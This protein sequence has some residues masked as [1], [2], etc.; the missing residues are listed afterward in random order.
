[1][2]FSPSATPTF[3]R[4][5]IKPTAIPTVVLPGV[6]WSYYAYNGKYYSTIAASNGFDTCLN[7]FYYLPTDWILAPDDS[8]S[9]N[10]I[11]L[12]AWNTVTVVVASGRGYYSNSTY[13]LLNNE[14]S[15]WLSTYEDSHYKCAKCPCQVLIMY[16]PN[17]RKPSYSPVTYFPVASPSYFPIRYPSGTPSIKVDTT[18]LLIIHVVVP[19]IFG[20]CLFIAGC[21]MVI[22]FLFRKHGNADTMQA[23]V[24]PTSQQ[25]DDNNITDN[26]NSNGILL[27]PQPI[28]IEYQLQ[29]MVALQQSVENG[30]GLQ[31]QQQQYIM[32]IQP[33]YIQL[34]PQQATQPQIQVYG[35]YGQSQ[36]EYGQQIVYDNA[37]LQLQSLPQAYAQSQSQQQQAYAFSQPPL[38]GQQQIYSFTNSQFQ[39]QSQLQVSSNYYIVLLIFPFQIKFFVCISF[40]D[41]LCTLFGSP[42]WLLARTTA[43]PAAAAVIRL[44]HC[45]PRGGCLDVQ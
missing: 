42:E 22:L 19:S 29:P 11:S 32:Q 41:L 23:Q 33:G 44:E 38:Q 16:S 45:A 26:N 24:K 43:S 7:Y 10:A 18:A 36:P 21:S 37:Q 13:G 12:N 14:Y 9:L 30:N 40:A 2:N 8:N 17:S 3:Q 5:S 6:W 15:N 25:E 34:Q 31:Q 4:T 39:T 35:R 1:M 27:Q 28:A 20:S